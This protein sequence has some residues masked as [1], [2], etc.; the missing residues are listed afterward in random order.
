LPGELAF[1]SNIEKVDLSKVPENIPLKKLL[2]EAHSEFYVP[3]Y[4]RQIYKFINDVKLKGKSV[5]Q[6]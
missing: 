3:Q 2:A 1:D 5:L 6:K 4:K